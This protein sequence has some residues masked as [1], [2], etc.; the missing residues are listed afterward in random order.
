MW[1]LK[2]VCVHSVIIV[3]VLKP[4]ALEM[5]IMKIEMEKENY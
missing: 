2:A 5:E 1:V 4:N 3:F